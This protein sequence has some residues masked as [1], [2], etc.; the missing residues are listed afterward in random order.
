[1][2]CGGPRVT[3][4]DGASCPM[5]RYYLFKGVILELVEAQQ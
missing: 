3:V 2:A 4:G 5:T 1:M